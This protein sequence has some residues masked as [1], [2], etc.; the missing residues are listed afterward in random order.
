MPFARV[1][2]LNM[3]YEIQGSGPQLLFISGTGGDL[4][5]KPGVFDWPLAKTFTVLAY[6]QRGLGR[7]GAP[8]GGYTMADYAEDANALL[9]AVGWETC[10]AM[11][12]SFGALDG[13]GVRPAPSRARGP[14][15]PCLYF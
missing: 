15:G 4:R 12:V 1:R 5:S 11:G 2:D 9:D 14:V 10:Y 13:A 3:Y 8:E 6:D 7:T